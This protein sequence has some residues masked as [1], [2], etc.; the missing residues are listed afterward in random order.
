MAT[1]LWTCHAGDIHADA[2]AQT[3]QHGRLSP[4]QSIGHIFYKSK[5]RCTLPLVYDQQA[6]TVT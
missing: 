4:A 5:A 3:L 2:T 1:F 6:Q